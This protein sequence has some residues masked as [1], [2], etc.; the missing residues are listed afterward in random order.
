MLSASKLEMN[1]QKQKAATVGRRQETI[2]FSK[3]SQNNGFAR[4]LY[5]LSTFLCRSLQNNN[6]K[7]FMENERKRRRSRFNFLS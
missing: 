4:A 3:M 2:G 6:V 1:Q 5:S 7:Y